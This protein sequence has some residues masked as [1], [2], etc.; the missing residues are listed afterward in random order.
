MWPECPY[1]SAVCIV[2]NRITSVGTEAEALRACGPAARRVNL[3]GSTIVPGLTDSHA[4]IMLEASRLLQ[5]DLRPARSVAEMASIA[6]QFAKANPPPAPGGWLQGFGW[7]QST[8]AGGAFP[9]HADLDEAIPTLPAYLQHVSG[10]AA[11]L[12]RAALELLAPLPQSVEGG[13]VLRDGAGRPTGILTDNAMNLATARIPPWS[14]ATADAALSRVLD[15]CTAS[16]LTGVHDLAAF[17]ADIALFS[18]RAAV[19]PSAG[20]ASARAGLRL[21]VYAMRRAD[22]AS[23]TAPRIVP[24]AGGVPPDSLLTVRA[25][26]LFADGAMGSWSAAMIEPY[27]DRPKQRGTLVYSMAALL[28]N[29]SAWRRQGYQVATHAI[30]DRANRQVL[31]AYEHSFSEAVDECRE[32]KPRSHR[33][34]RLQRGAGPLPSAPQLRARPHAPAEHCLAPPQHTSAREQREEFSLSCLVLV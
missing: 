3:N 23:P 5:A 34:R 12:N 33:A 21:R 4:H 22:E 32:E 1:A 8:W 19:T 27:A 28:A 6:V 31:D 15:E 17:G 11:L 13:Q 30:G 18:K 24:G 16:G 26:K 10:H 14:E 20:A 7:D 29:V 9:T 25:V 2:A